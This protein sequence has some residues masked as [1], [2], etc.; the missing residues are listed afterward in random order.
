MGIL[1]PVLAPESGEVIRVA[2]RDGQGVEYGQA[3]MT[4]SEASDPGAAR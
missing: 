1:N 4:L 2:A 3:L